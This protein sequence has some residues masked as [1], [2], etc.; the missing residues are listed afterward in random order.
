MDKNPDELVINVQL[1]FLEIIA[2]APS[3]KDLTVVHYQH[4][5]DNA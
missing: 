1:Q 3:D 4:N 5:M 2:E